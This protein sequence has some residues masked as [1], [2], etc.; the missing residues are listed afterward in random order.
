MLCVPKILPLLLL[1]L[2]VVILHLLFLLLT[3][4][5][6]RSAAIAPPPASLIPLA[7]ICS[8][9]TKMR[10]ISIHASAAV[11]AGICEQ[12][13]SFDLI[14]L[15]GRRVAGSR[16]PDVGDVPQ[17]LLP[18]LRQCSAC[19][20]LSVVLAL[21]PWSNVGYNQVQRC[22]HL[23]NLASFINFRPPPPPAP[24]QV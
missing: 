5:I 15:N 8:T 13:Y 22:L 20:V 21:L 23:D 9:S 7:S 4:F 10:C 17:V 3:L 16:Q 14:A 18:L 2:C 6:L 1:S 12:H 19:Q 11:L 24:P